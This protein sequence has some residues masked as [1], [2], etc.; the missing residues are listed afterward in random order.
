MTLLYEAYQSSLANKE[1]KKLFYPRVVRVGN[2]NTD[3]IADE[4][5]RYSSLSSGDVK[6]TLDNLVTVMTQHL[7]ASESV[8]LDGFGTFR[9]IMKSKGKGA[10]SLAEVTAAQST[11]QIRFLPASTLNN[12]RTKA[13]RS[14]LTGA[15]CKRYDRA[16]GTT[17]GEEEI[18]GGEEEGGGIE[19]I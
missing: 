4:I 10:S 17:S 16:T 8:T 5:S 7:Q 12:D 2:V 15:K 6:N 11:L 13:T 9:I 18:P 1:G 14:L 19:G 3:V